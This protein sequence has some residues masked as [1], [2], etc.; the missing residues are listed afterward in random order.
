[1]TVSSYSRESDPPVEQFSEWA[2]SDTIES[3]SPVV[4]RI[5]VGLNISNSIKGASDILLIGLVF[6][7][8]FPFATVI[9]D[10]GDVIP[11]IKPSM[12]VIG[13]QDS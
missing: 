11:V 1:M 7:K 3:I 10:R 5:N 8:G 9:N 4:A 13:K 2:S 6:C 12:A